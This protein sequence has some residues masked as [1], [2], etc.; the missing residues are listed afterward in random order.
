MTEHDQNQ[1]EGQDAHPLEI[2]VAW[3]F[4]HAL[5]LWVWLRGHWK[6]E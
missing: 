6:Q 4:F 1:S 5:A 3:L 2:A